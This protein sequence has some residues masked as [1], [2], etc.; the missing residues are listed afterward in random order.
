MIF[1]SIYPNL[2]PLNHPNQTLERIHF[3]GSTKASKKKQ[4]TCVQDDLQHMVKVNFWPLFWVDV[5][6]FCVF[7]RGL[8]K[9]LR[10][11]ANVFFLLIL[12]DDIY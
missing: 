10:S 3:F 2:I 1:F 5:F 8:E 4:V 12:N 7:T 11:G 6:F 9:R